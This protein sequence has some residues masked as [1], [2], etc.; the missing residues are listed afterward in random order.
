MARQNDVWLY[1]CIANEPEIL[2]DTKTG[3]YIRGSF[4]LAVMRSSRNSGEV[5]NK[6]KVMYDWPYILSNDPAVIAQMENLKIHD[7]ME[8]RGKFVTRKIRK[9]TKCKNC[10]APIAAIGNLDFVM[11]LVMKRRNTKGEQLTEK[12]AFREIA[13]NRELSNNIVIVGNVCNEVTYHHGMQGN[14]E[15]QTSVYQIATDR[16]VYVPGDPQEIRTDFPMIRS[17]GRQAKQDHLCLNVGS[18]VLINGYLHSR[19][20]ERTTQCD[21]CEQ[22]FQ[23]T[24]SITEIVP[25][26]EEYLTNYNDPG[27]KMEEDDLQV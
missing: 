3:E 12:Q 8:I 26:S 19:E 2:K 6:D 16:R 17:Y 23:W 27:D 20:F 4:Y 18:S 15:I 1:G 11:P 21:S 9:M 7:V 22:A 5:W 25:Y 10:G 13:D 14:R 24:D